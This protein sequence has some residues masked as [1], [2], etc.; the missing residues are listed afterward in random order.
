MPSAGWASTPPQALAASS[1]PG[2]STDLPVAVDYQPAAAG[3]F[4]WQAF[5]ATTIRTD[6][7]TI[8]GHG[9]RLVRVGLAWDS[10]MPDARGVDRRRLADL[11]SLLTAARTEGVAVVLTLFIQAH[12]DCVFLPSRAVRRGGTVGGVRVLSDGILEP[13]VPRDPWTDPLMLELADRWAE[14][15]AAEFAGHA[16]VAGWDLGDDPASVARPRRRGDLAAWARVA[17]APFRAR[18]ERVTLTLGAGDVLS[19][20]AVRIATFSGLVD[21]IDLAAR[22]EELLD[23]EL[24]T[25][26][27][28][29]FLVELGQGLG[30]AD[31]PPIG[32][33]LAF[34]SALALP[35]AQA[36]VAEPAARVV[37]EV[38][39]RCDESGIASMRGTR[40]SDLMPRLG[41][42][43]PYDRAP[44]MLGCGLIASA[45]EP[46]PLLAPWARCAR[47]DREQPPPRAWPADL[48][49]EAYYR[50][51]PDSVLDLAARWR[52]ERADRPGILGRGEA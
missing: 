22:P 17:A 21:R 43:A 10:F 1:L 24:P 4:L 28:F 29:R 34:P 36:D 39:E 14:T 44:W 8:A 45:G 3:P 41:E 11:D 49:A 12:G 19:P 7:G 9:F 13:G 30:G 42:R 27:A 38:I 32:L 23:L 37:D 40:W 47:S 48:D 31:G 26:S 20:R 46:K 16:A 6:L 33:A 5:D 51:L 35:D 15:L 50:H 2:V 25:A 18:G 52:R